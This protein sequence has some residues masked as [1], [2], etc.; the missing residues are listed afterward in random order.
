MD[1][2][3]D[4][5]GN[6]CY[7]N[8]TIQCL[9]NFPEFLSL[10]QGDGEITKLMKTLMNSVN[11]KDQE[12]INCSLK[13]L[14]VGFQSKI[15]NKMRVFAQNDLCEFILLLFDVLT[16]EMKITL[17]TDET[18]KLKQDLTKKFNTITSKTIRNFNLICAH[19]WVDHFRKEYNDLDYLTNFMSVS[20]IKCDC[21]KL[22]HNYEFNNTL[23]LDVTDCKSLV[24]CLNQYVKSVTFNEA[25][26][27]N[28]IEW[29]CDACNKQQPSKKVIT[30]WQF[31][32]ILIIFLKRFVMNS[33]GKFAKLNHEVY[34]PEEIDLNKYALNSCSS[35]NYKLKSIGCH[36]GRLNFGHYYALLKKSDD[37]WFQIDDENKNEIKELHPKAYRDGYMLVYHRD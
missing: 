28:T 3:L 26:N 2:T 5:L 21:S 37:V 1:F 7:F 9:F 25:D 34:F 6:T 19:K 10:L 16:N 30:F 32:K 11:K 22:H 20:Q 18:K 27:E 29:T 12:G 23:Q 13:D 36:V 24:E 14:L 17:S 35:T 8:T 31:P 15:E 33:S 4:N